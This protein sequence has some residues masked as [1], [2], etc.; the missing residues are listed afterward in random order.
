MGIA[1]AALG[2]LLLSAL[3]FVVI[4]DPNTAS[5]VG[6]VHDG[7][8]IAL[9]LFILGRSLYL[10]RAGN[11]STSPAVPSPPTQPP[12]ETAKPPAPLPTQTGEALILLSL[13]QEKGRF[14]DYLMEDVTAFSDA[15]VAAASR[16]VHQGCSA[17]IRECLALA[18]AHDGKEGERISIEASTDPQ[19][20]RLIGKVQAP[21]FS[22]VVV[23]RGWK[24]S[25]LALPRHTRPIDPAGENVI[26]PVEV[27]VR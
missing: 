17:V 7:G 18:P 5:I 27:E 8:V 12:A 20:Y 4:P 3:S 2:V 21:P 11:R 23:H 26:T 25:K 14:L 1:I 10:L 24:T 9:S 15:Q 19:Q 6:W 22:G 13:L 16:V